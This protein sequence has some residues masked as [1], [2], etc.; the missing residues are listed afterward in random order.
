MTRA[1]LLATLRQSAQ[2][3]GTYA[4]DCPVLRVADVEAVL[5][6]RLTVTDGQKTFSVP[7]ATR[8]RLT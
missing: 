1:Q 2:P 7:R 5:E 8:R 4:P 6:G 3:A